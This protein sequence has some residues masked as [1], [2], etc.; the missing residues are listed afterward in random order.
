KNVGLT[1]DVDQGDRV[2][3]VDPGSAADRAG[4]RAGD[5]LQRLNGQPV[6]SF[7]DVRHAL[8][9]APKVGTVPVAWQRGGKDLSGTL[10]L[11]DGWRESDISWRPSMWALSPSA[12]VYGEDLSA[13]DKRKLGLPEKRL[14]FRQGLFVGAAAK[15]AGVR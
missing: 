10:E 4:V 7:A 15:S 13:E 11:R 6:S 3:A 8:D 12:C 2:L 9:L 14:A 1:L 5:V